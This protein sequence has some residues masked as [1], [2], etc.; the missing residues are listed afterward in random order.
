MIEEM[1]VGRQK[2]IAL[3][4]KLQQP[5]TQ[6]RV[7]VISGIGGIGKSWLLEYLVQESH[8]IGAA[9]VKISVEEIG[10]W[11][12]I[13]LEASYQLGIEHF[14]DF[15]NFIKEYQDRRR[16]FTVGVGQ[17]EE[18]QTLSKRATAIFI[19][20]LRTLTEHQ[21]LVWLFDTFE[22]AN[23]ST[24]AWVWGQ[25]LEGILQENKI[26]NIV[27]L[28]AGR[29]VSIPSEWHGRILPHE[30]SYFTERDVLDYFKKS[31]FDDVD[32][33][34]VSKLF[35]LTTGHPLCIAVVMDVIEDLKISGKGF[36]SDI[37][38]GYEREFEETLVVEFLI[39]TL[40]QRVEQNNSDEVE[41]IKRSAITRWFNYETIEFLSEGK[42]HEKILEKVRLYSFVRPH[43]NGYTYHEI[44]I[45]LLLADWRRLNPNRFVELNQ[46]ALEY[47]QK[48][49]KTAITEKEKKDAVVEQVYHKVAI[50]END[51]I[52]F[53]KE[54]FQRVYDFYD[55]AQ[56]M[57]LLE[58][59][60]ANPIK[61]ADN[62]TTTLFYDVLVA[63]MTNQWNI[64]IGVGE[65]FLHRQQQ[66]SDMK[67]DVL[68]K[69]ATAYRHK[70]GGESLQKAIE[71]YN[72]SLEINQRQPRINQRSLRDTLRERAECYR[73]IGELDKAE[74]DLKE[75]QAIAKQLQSQSPRD[76]HAVGMG[77]LYLGNLTRSFD[78]WEEA[79][80]AYQ[81]A[82][83]IFRNLDHY[84][85]NRTLYGL[86]YIALQKGAWKE[87]I[88]YFEEAHQAFL[89]SGEKYGIAAT[90]HAVGRG[91]ICVKDYDRA[92]KILEESLTIFRQF[93]S[94]GNVSR[95]LGDLGRISYKKGEY[96][97]AL[98]YFTRVFER[99]G[100]KS[101]NTILL[102]VLRDNGDLFCDQ[103]AFVKAEESY[104]EAL[105]IAKNMRGPFDIV[106][107]S[108]RLCHLFYRCGRSQEVPGY[109]KQ[110][111]RI[112]QEYTFFDQLSSLNSVE[113]HILLDQA[114]YADAFKAYAKACDYAIHYNHYVL[115]DVFRQLIN[116][117]QT[118]DVTQLEPFYAYIEK[119][120][121]ENNIE[122]IES[123]IRFRE[124]GDNTPQFI[125]MLHN[126][127]NNQQKED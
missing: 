126:N 39:K 94:E 86:G 103:E 54:Q 81:E 78:K 4:H 121:E 119:Y 109:I 46:K 107:I 51:G 100:R 2:E 97:L 111:E 98:H 57:S 108:L 68:D 116:H 47:F 17:T 16:P 23:Q 30:L 118:K 26:Q 56:C 38:D 89:K 9:P 14:T 96:D 88:R 104:Q 27:F 19:N 95:L 64:I 79:T 105:T 106:Q 63:S 55:V 127:Q 22:R 75:S 37:L 120:W 72:Q 125:R 102:P 76:E 60:Q 122:R 124:T 66:Q 84:E 65:K 11:I 40:L 25:L 62:Q 21:A 90:G 36:S 49:E 80:E 5:D 24:Q 8:R 85:Y 20:C 83:I 70:L 13:L 53:F 42:E 112:M 48:K 10:S 59:V 74:S 58:A 99:E 77:Y 67:A 28:I 61:R 73:L 82:V 113:G 45:D 91:Y 123:E 1:F 44:V 29:E 41:V 15:I 69:I 52:I 18:V 117:I 110:I 50:N 31:N 12:G 33:D 114:N 35:S 7:V 87:A 93:G 43:R 6:R 115:E 71:F 3:F 101:Q 92:A 32:P 34:F